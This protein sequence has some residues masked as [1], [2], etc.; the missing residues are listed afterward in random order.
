M[1]D[2]AAVAVASRSFS[3]HPV[4]RAELLQRYPNTRF[5]DEGTSLRGETLVEFLGGRQKAI[6]ALEPIDEGL[7]RR[8]PEL[9][10]ISKVGVGL[11]MVDLEALERHGVQLAWSPG[12]NS[13]S[14]AELALTLALSLLRHLQVVCREVHE[15]RWRQPKGRL[16]SDR[17]LGLIGYGNVARDLAE[18]VA[19]FACPVLAYDVRP[20][21]DLPHHVQAVDLERLLREA[22]IVTLH[23]DLNPSTR[24]VLD[25]ERLS[26]MKPSAILLNTARPGL[27]DEEA[28]ASMLREGRLAG[29]GLD[30]LEEE[31]PVDSPLIGIDNVLVTPHIGGSTEEG[32]LAMGRAAIDGLDSPRSVAQLRAAMA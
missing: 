27:I 11:D 18:L 9:R 8:T 29:A 4:L 12:T 23:V 14:V 31:P 22:D 15:G 3:R 7:L 26:L 20:L 25:A 10:V 16:L 19:P 30:V 13:R 17:T 2:P 6:T 5:N 1:S 32:I 24:R 21:S 28:L